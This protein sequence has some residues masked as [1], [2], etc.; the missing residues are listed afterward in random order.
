MKYRIEISNVVEGHILGVQ[1]YLP[2]VTHS[3]LAISALA[4]HRT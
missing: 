2:A 1:C 3:L 4:T